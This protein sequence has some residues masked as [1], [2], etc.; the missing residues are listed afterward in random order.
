MFKTYSM[1][2]VGIL[3]VVLSQFIPA[4]VAGELATDIMLVVGLVISWIGRYRVGDLTLY[5]TR[6]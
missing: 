5:G 4:D 1:T 6:K 3:T 2:F